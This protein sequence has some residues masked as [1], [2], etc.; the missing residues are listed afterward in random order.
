[1]ACEVMAIQEPTMLPMQ[2]PTMQQETAWPRLVAM[3]LVPAAMMMP[4]PQ[5]SPVASQTPSEGYAASPWGQETRRAEAAASDA[6]ERNGTSRKRNGIVYDAYDYNG[7][8]GK[9]SRRRKPRHAQPKE[10]GRTQGEWRK[11]QWKNSNSFWNSMEFWTIHACEAP[12]MVPNR[13]AEEPLPLDANQLVKLRERFET[14]NM[15]QSSLLAH[16]ELLGWVWPYSR[17]PAGCRAVQSA[18]VSTKPAVGKAIAQELHGHD[19]DR[20]VQALLQPGI[21][22]ELA[23]ADFGSYVVRTLLKHPKVDAQVLIQTI[24]GVAACLEQ[25]VAAACVAVQQQREISAGHGVAHGVD[26]Q[27]RRRCHEPRPR[28]GQWQRMA[29]LEA[30][31]ARRKAL[32]PVW[33]R[34]EG[35]GMDDLPTKDRKKEEAPTPRAGGR[36]VGRSSRRTSRSRSRKDA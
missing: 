31:D 20:L 22:S 19:Q 36:E 34:R 3:M 33:V 24:P 15:D 32:R 28:T 13:Y 21:I 27:R 23:K 4:Q 17:D 7:A 11:G 10:G 30:G 25:H 8:Y 5:V 9:N 12:G 26:E 6:V 16:A 29:S 14:A 2:L 18:I 1:M 35:S